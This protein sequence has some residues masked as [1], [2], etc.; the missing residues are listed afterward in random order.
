MWD[1]QFRALASGYFVARYDL[2]GFGESEASDAPFSQVEVLAG[3]LE[4]LD[5]SAA[6]LVGL[7]YGA[8]CVIDFALA[9]PERVQSM[10][11]A[12]PG[13]SGYPWSPE[14][15]QRYADLFRRAQQEGP[16]AAVEHWLQDPHLQPAMERSPLDERLR[17]LHQDNQQMYVQPAPAQPE[18]QPAID[19]LS[20]IEIPTLVVIGDRDVTDTQEV[21]KLLDEQVGGATVLWVAGAGHIVNMEEPVAFNQGLMSFLTERD[22]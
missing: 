20:E 8:S 12:A 10:V 9:H 7:S 14:W 17:E 13:L 15:T 19:R 5:L 18:K 3:V 16:E 6:H 4:H 22:G 11:L 2:P 1:D 21:A